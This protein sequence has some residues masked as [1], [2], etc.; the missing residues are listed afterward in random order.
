MSS[1]CALTIIKFLRADRDRA[2][3]RADLIFF[4]TQ[5]SHTVGFDMFAAY[6]IL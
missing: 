6:S 1:H 4:V 2:N 5:K 3:V